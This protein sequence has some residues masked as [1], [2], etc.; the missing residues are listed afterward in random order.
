MT[1][2]ID[3]PRTHEPRDGA[4]ETCLAEL[5]DDDLHETAAASPPPR[6]RAAGQAAR[7]PGTATPVVVGIYAR[8]SCDKQ[9]DRSLEDQIRRC[10]EEAQRKG[11]WVDERH[12]YTDAAVSGLKD[13]REGY[14]RMMR[15]LSEGRLH[16]VVVDE[17]SRLTRD[18]VEQARLAQ[19]LERNARLRLITVDGLDTRDSDWGLRLGIQGLLA[20]QES[21]RIRHRVTR[22]MLGQLQRG[23]MIATA[24]LGYRLKREFDAVGNRIGT[25]WEIDEAQAEIVREI[26]HR[27]A[28]GESMHQIATWLNDSGVPCTRAPLSRRGGFWRPSRVRQLLSNTIYRGVFVW[29][30]STT[31]QAQCRKKGVEPEVQEIERPELRL[32][33]DELWW[34]CAEKTSISR[35]GYGGGRHALSGLLSCGCCGATLSLTSKPDKR[36]VFCQPCTLAKSTNG[37]QDRL[38]GTIRVVGIELLLQR[39]LQYFLSEPLMEAFRAALRQRL[40][41][42]ARQ[43][44]QQAHKRLAELQKAQQRLARMLEHTSEDDEVLEE[45][46]R[47]LRQKVMQAQQRVAQLQQH[48]QQLDEQALE[49]QL[50]ADPRALLPRL[51]D[52]RVAPHELRAL[53]RQLFPQITFVTKRGRYLSIF[54]IRFAPGVALARASHTPVLSTQETEGWFAL[55]YVNNHGRGQQPRWEVQVLQPPT[56]PATPVP[57][58]GAGNVNGAPQQPEDAAAN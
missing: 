6:T 52:E 14:Q 48:A 49:A 7:P 3:E 9:Q 18:G 12:I 47:A 54:R 29:H 21:H 31:Y 19:M 2:T 40:S 37:E 22:G 41:G 4:D 25:R 20:Q 1:R 51:W 57:A 15:A 16:V 43:E 10:R 28:A 11:L 56:E 26:Y 45:R 44:L 50:Q 42:D 53:L 55:R 46:Y 5:A 17:I 30:G 36:S 13:D 24:A 8:Y 27:R 32:V 34:A 35:S 38:T 58:E 23:Y 39:A 33:S